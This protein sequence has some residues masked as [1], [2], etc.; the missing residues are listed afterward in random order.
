[1]TGHELVVLRGH[2]GP[3]R[4][5]VF[6]ADCQRV[7]T[8]S[9]D[10]TVR[11]WEARP[12][13][14]V[15]RREWQSIW[16]GTF[17]PD[18]RR[19]YLPPPTFDHQFTA[20]ILDTKTG[21]EIARATDVKWVPRK[22]SAC[23]SPDGKLLLTTPSDMRKDVYIVDA[24]T[25]TV[26]VKLQGHG[27]VVSSMAFSPNGH[28]VVTTDGQGQIWDARMG[29]LLYLLPSN[30][31]DRIEDATIS[32]DGRT[33]ATWMTKTRVLERIL[34]KGRQVLGAPACT[35][36]RV[37]DMETGKQLA[38][39]EGHG[40]AV[41]TAVFSPDGTRLV[42]AS[43]D[44]TVRVWD[45]ATGKELF[46]RDDKGVGA[47]AFSPDGKLVA[48]I[49]ED[50]TARVWY[51]STGEPRFPLRGHEGPIRCVGF[52]PRRAPA[53][54]RLGRQNHPSV[55]R[56]QRGRGRCIGCPGRRQFSSFQQ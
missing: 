39:M 47:V 22:M 4:T 31:D 56:C 37:W 49:S 52:Q 16:P 25:L 27:G 17:S 28:K 48:S 20:R 41:R 6:R 55:E 26:Q 43:T 36:V 32:P 13:F 33:L 7:L 34:A 29:K 9:V 40:K 10:G 42:T 45:T 24:V 51:A 11:L 5:A 30:E 18:G 35:T 15:A 54:H 14:P 8:A 50:R 3:V 2:D 38:I 53:R 46:H 19:L 12:G 23:F 44:R 1:M 21:A